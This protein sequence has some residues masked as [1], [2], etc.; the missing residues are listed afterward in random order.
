[1]SSGN[2]V[3]PLV[4]GV[5][6]LNPPTEQFTSLDGGDIYAVPNAAANISVENPVLNPA[7]YGLDFWESLSGELVTVK[8]PVAITRP[9]QYGDTWVIG[10]W[11]TT[12]RNAHG[13]LTMS[14]KGKSASS[15]QPVVHPLT[16]PKTPTPRPSSSAPLSTAPRTP[17]PR[18]ATSSPR[19][20]AL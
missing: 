2:K 9:N 13:G 16:V 17:S 6:T 10:D 1:M 20:P 11:P 19:S 8:T 18:W 12:G 3:T 15:R 14:D 7:L 5:D 4:I